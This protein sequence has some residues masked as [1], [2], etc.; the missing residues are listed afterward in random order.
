MMSC[1]IA[2]NIPAFFIGFKV[3]H[4]RRDVNG[5]RVEPR[6]FRP[7]WLQIGIIE[8]HRSEFYT[9]FGCADQMFFRGR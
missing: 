3:E 6:N 5:S 8:R 4:F 2:V 1:T 9:C 7:Q